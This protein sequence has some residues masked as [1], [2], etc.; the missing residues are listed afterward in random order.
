M[1][2]N[3]LNCDAIL[4]GRSDKKF[5]DAICRSAFHNQRL[6][7]YHQHIRRVNRVLGLNRKI[8]ERLIHRGIKVTTHQTLLQAG[9]DF[10]LC[11][12]TKLSAGNA[13]I[14]HIYEFAYQTL[15]ENRIILKKIAAA[16]TTMQ[17]VQS[18]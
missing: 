9:F 18:A 8:L 3:C 7:E 11:T 12:G 13:P 15:S 2:K 17:K 10:D 5:C 14:Y 16:T 1:I 4:H 6:K